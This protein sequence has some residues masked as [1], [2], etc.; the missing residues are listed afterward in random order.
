MGVGC[1]SARSRTVANQTTVRCQAAQH[2]AQVECIC[3][4][5][6]IQLA[7][8]LDARNVWHVQSSLRPRSPN[9]STI[10]PSESVLDHADL[11]AQPSLIDHPGRASLFALLP[12]IKYQSRTQRPGAVSSVSVLRAVKTSL[13]SGL[14]R[15]RGYPTSQEMRVSRHLPLDS[16][17]E[18]KSSKGHLWQ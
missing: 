13:Q 6:R 16:K 12:T 14:N 5:A 3:W 2:N 8:S 1:G 7:A 15:V 4:R 17:L 18:H 10:R 11:N 9:W